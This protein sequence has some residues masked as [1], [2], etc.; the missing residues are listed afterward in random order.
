MEAS[1][2]KKQF[3]HWYI[4]KYWFLFSLGGCVDEVVDSQADYQGYRYDVNFLRWHIFAVIHSMNGEGICWII[5]RTIFDVYSL[6][7]S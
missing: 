4:L 6:K 5:I 7:H 2:Q 3:S 1:F